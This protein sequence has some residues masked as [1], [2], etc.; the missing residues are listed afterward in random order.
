M[1]KNTCIFLSITI[2][3]TV[4]VSTITGCS[5]KND[6]KPKSVNSTVASKHSD[7]KGLL[8]KISNGKSIVYLYGSFHV[9]K[10]DMLPLGKT[11]ENAFINSNNLVVEFNPNNT[12]EIQKNQYKMY[13]EGNDNVYNHLSSTGKD[14][15]NTLAKELSLNMNDLEKLKIWAV[16]ST[17]L[18]TELSKLGFSNTGV[19]YYFLNK[20]TN[21]QKILELESAEKQFDVLNEI[22]DSEQEQADLINI[23]DMNQEGLKFEKMYEAYKAGN[24]KALVQLSIDQIKKYT[25]SYKKIVVDRNIVIADKIDEYLKTNDSYFVVA[26]TAHFIGDDSVINLLKEKGYK[27]NRL[28]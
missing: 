20:S 12:D 14:K 28:H 3:L 15:V 6:N 18:Y 4:I 11:I 8:W 24:E 19:D 25:N 1:R 16:N 22:P 26:G 21:G 9:M 13:Y 5:T 7:I 27:V 10:G 2:I 17:F 23:S